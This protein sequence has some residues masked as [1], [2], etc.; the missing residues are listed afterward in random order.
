M[1]VAYETPSAKAPKPLIK[2]D[3]KPKAKPTPKAPSNPPNPFP[4]RTYTTP[5]APSNFEPAKRRPS[6]SSFLSLRRKTVSDSPPPRN[7]VPVPQLRVPLPRPVHL[8][9]TNI[10]PVDD[11]PPIPQRSDKASR[12]LGK[13]LPTQPTHDDRGFVV[14]DFSATFRISPRSSMLDEDTSS[15]DTGSSIA[16]SDE[17]YTDDSHIQ[18]ESQLLDPI[19]FA[20]MRPQ[21]M[22][23]VPP[24]PPSDNPSDDDEWAEPIT[25]VAP[26]PSHRTR[27][28]SQPHQQHSRTES[29]ASVHD[30]YS[31]QHSRESTFMQ[32]RPDPDTFRPDTPFLDTLVAVNSQVVVSRGNQHAREQSVVRTEPK[33]GWMGEWN[34]DDMQDVIHKLRSLK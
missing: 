34:Q 12:M 13:P 9:Q 23:P 27:A 1:Y 22:T 11:L 26:L 4:I 8:H 7:D 3:K 31:N 29:Y 2:L 20:A 25:P 24:P 28:V 21:S 6:V 5:S 17:A 15:L 16:E 30:H 19:E 14:S 10:H 32:F 33:Q 18:R